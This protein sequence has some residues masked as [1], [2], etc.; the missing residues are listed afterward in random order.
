[1]RNRRPP[2]AVGVAAVAVVL[3]A[4]GCTAGVEPAWQEVT[5]PGMSPSTLFAGAAGV[6]VGGQVEPG[7]LPVL[8][9]RDGDGWRGIPATPVTGY[10]QVATFVAGA[11]DPAGRIVVVGTATGGAHLNPRWTTWT[12]DAA[13]IVEEPQTPE[14]FGGWSA[15]GVTAVAYGAEPAIVGAWSVS[16]GAT[17]VAVWR[18]R[19]TAWVREPSPPE[20]VGS[21]PAT[22]ESAAAA[23]SV[24]AA[25][26]IVG[27]Q[28]DLAGGAVHQRAQLWRSDG[29]PWSRIDLDTS[30][31]DSAATDVACTDADCLAVGRLDGTLAAWRVTG[32][33]VERV[34]LPDRTVDRYTGQPRV[35]REGG[36]IVIA[37]GAGAVLLTGDAAGHRWVVTPT[38]AGDVRGLA[39]HD[40]AVLL[41]LRDGSGAQQVYRRPG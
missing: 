23:T 35:A 33:R 6:F 17:G 12:G 10:G 27:L 25:T 13:G 36:L 28:T 24:G 37:V 4:G 14:T 18:H 2:I 29:G 7:A 38:P 34:T 22:S 8:D 5:P 21:P 20:F 39:V 1:M 11:A 40:G 3:L 41:L 15:G 32:D 9:R 30:G 31:A 19:A 16:D 26:V